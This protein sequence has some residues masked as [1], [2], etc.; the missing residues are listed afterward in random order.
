MD[1]LSSLI[2]KNGVIILFTL[3]VGCGLVWLGERFL[4]SRL[5]KWLGVK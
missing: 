1:T 5:V 2:V 4:P 3:A